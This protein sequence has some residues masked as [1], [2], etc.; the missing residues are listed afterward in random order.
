MALIPDKLKNAETLPSWIFTIC[1]PLVAFGLYGKSVDLSKNERFN[2]KCHTSDDILTHRCISQFTSKTVFL[3]WINLAA[4]LIGCFII[5]VTSAAMSRYKYLKENPGHHTF[6]LHCIYMIRLSLLMLV[7]AAAVVVFGFFDKIIMI[8]NQFRCNIDNQTI[9]CY[10]GKG[11]DKTAINIGIMVIN[12][13][14][15]LWNLL[16]LIHFLCK[17]RRKSRNRDSNGDLCNICQEFIKHFLHSD[18][19]N[20]EYHP[21]MSIQDVFSTVP[22]LELSQ[23]DADQNIFL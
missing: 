7:F 14:C 12:G 20:Q 17:W 5:L 13:L 22:D 6:H 10:E 15:F 11:P 16:E 3:D 21:L 23:T 19:T 18:G 9:L 2:I 1:F 8:G 4:I